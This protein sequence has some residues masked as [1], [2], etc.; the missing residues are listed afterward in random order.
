M[1][2]GFFSVH[3]N[4]SFKLH[5]L[6]PSSRRSFNG[7]YSVSTVVL[8]SKPIII[9][10]CYFSSNYIAGQHDINAIL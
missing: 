8:L 2:F 6:H 9:Q 5:M 3:A 10:I 7:K 1:F 4:M